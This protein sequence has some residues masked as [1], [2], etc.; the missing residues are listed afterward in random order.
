MNDLSN[1][2]TLADFKRAHKAAGGHFFDRGAMRFFESRI[3][4]GLLKGGYFITSERFASISYDADIEIPSRMFHVRK[5]D[6]EWPLGIDRIGD[7][8]E[9]REDAMDAVREHRG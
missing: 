5:I 2:K 4:S 7:H 8:Y 3:E 1:F 6:E 9:T